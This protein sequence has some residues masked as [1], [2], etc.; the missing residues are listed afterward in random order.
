MRAHRRSLVGFDIAALL[1]ILAT[2]LLVYGQVVDHEFVAWDDSS[3]VSE[4][5]RVLQGLHW[6]NVVWAFSTFQLANWHPITLLS[7]MLDVSLWG[8]NPG[9]HAAVNLG[10]HISNTLL[11]YSFFRRTSHKGAALF[12]AF[13]ALFVSLLFAVHPLHVESVAWIS[14]RK[15]VLCA[16][17]WLLAMHAYVGYAGRPSWP[18]YLEVTLWIALSMMSKPM[19]VTLPLALAILDWWPLQRTQGI[20]QMIARRLL[21]EKLPWI[22]MALVVGVLTMNAQVNAM[23]ALDLL[24]RVQVAIVAYSWYLEK[25][26]WPSGLHFYYITESA[27]S[28]YRYLISLIVLLLISVYAFIWRK[29]LPAFTAGWLWFLLTLLPVVGFVKVGT[30]AWADRYTYLPHIGLFWMFASLVSISS[31]TFTRKVIAVCSFSFALL[32]MMW[33]AY[34]QVGSWRDTTTLYRQALLHNPSHYVALMGL[35]NQ[36]LRQHEYA[37]ARRYADQAL[38]L[39]SGPALVRSMEALL[40]DVE[41]NSRNVSAA[42]KHY[43]RGAAIDPLDKTIRVKLGFAYIDAGHFTAAEAS[44]REALQIDHD[45]VDALSGLGVALGLQERWS[46]SVILL[47]RGLS[48][49]PENRGLLLNLAATALRSGDAAKAEKVYEALLSTNPTDPVVLDA[50]SRLSKQKE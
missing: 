47:E 9:F 46:E 48:I 35:A 12:G 11:I 25:T 49:A 15:D 42:I 44:F 26:F 23:P 27:W 13:T 50:I 34:G 33:V 17:F 29:K 21:Y 6:S 28:A 40:G 37:Q 20:S 3:Y 38:S 31:V 7:H 45:S 16:F 10:L 22:A 24:D 30:Q 5:Q 14:E 43:Q 18:R 8:A 4:N 19:A 1:A 2:A 41:F 36:A 39:S 32:G